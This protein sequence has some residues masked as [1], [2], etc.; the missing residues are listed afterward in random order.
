MLLGRQRELRAIDEGL[1][2]ARL[3]K[4]S[5]LVIRG[6]PGIGK[7]AL[8]EYA[9]QQA[10][11]MRLLAARGVEFEADVP[12]A[13][14][15]ELLQPALGLLD[16]LPSFHAT[17]LRSSL[18]L[19]PRIAA[20]RL[21]V[22]AAVLGLI[23]L[24]AEE[25]PLLITVD[26]AQWLDR[27]SAEAIGFAA[28]RLV[29][30]PVLVL[31]A[32]REG[33][34]SP[35]LAAGLP[36]LMLGGLDQEAA[37]E[38]L[39]NSGGGQ[40]SAEVT[41]RLVAATGGNPL[42][43]LEL[44][45][46]AQRVTSAPH[47]N[48][49]V[50]TSVERAYLRRA[51]G[52]SDSARNVLLLVAASGSSDMGLVRRA[53]A[54]LGVGELAIEEAEAAAS[55]VSQRA[56]RIE[57]VHPLARASIYHSASPAERRAA[58]R[59]L[60]RAMTGADDA[61]RR[62]WH[63]AAAA[64]DHD[65]EAADALEAAARRAHESSGYAAASAAWLESARLTADD[66]TRAARFFQAA[67]NAWLGGRAE[68]A[69]ESLKAARK[70]A[71]EGLQV[72]ID[73]LGGHIAMRRGSVLQ[74]YATLVAAAEAVEPR[75]RLK[76]IRILADAAISTF[77][78]GRPEEMLAA[79]RRAL[80]LLRPDD[81][82][83]AG[84]FAHVS[85]GA[86]AILAGHG[87]D[88]P[89]HL[90]ESVPLFRQLPQD[91]SDPLVLLCA[92]VTGLFLRE[93]E[94]GR[95]LL[96]RALVQAREHAPTGAL[97]SVLFT[98]ARDAFAT[99][100]W[101]LARALYEDAMRVA[102]E[103][104]QLTWLAGDVAGV[105]WLDALEGRADDC[106]TH[107]AEALELAESLGMGLYKAW[108]MI[109]IGM[110]ELGLG[111]PDE[112]LRQLAACDAFLQEISISDPDLSPAPDIVDAL[113]RL[114]R[115]PEAREV[116][117]RYSAAAAAKGQPF[118]LARAARAEALL[119]P[120][121]DFVARFESALRHHES[122]PDTFERART[123][124]YFGERLRRVRKR[125]EA[126]KQLRAALKA[127]DQLGAAP[128]ADRAMS[129]L[130]ASGETA[131]VRDDR[132]RQQLTPQ[133]L[134]VALTLAE[135]TT[136]REAAA[137]L[138]LSPKTVEYHL[139]H[140]YDKL[141]IR[142]R[143][144]LQAALMSHARPG[145]ARKTLMFTDLTSS[146]NL[147]EA[148]G[149]A[150]WHDLSAWLDGELRR[151]FKEHHGHEVDHAGDGFFVIFEAAAE[152]ID[153]AITVQRRLANHRRVHGY[154]PQVRI[155]I[156]SGEVQV[157]DSSVRGAAVHRAARLCA[158]ALGDTIVV[159]REALEASGRPLGGLHDFALKGIKEPVAAAEVS[160]A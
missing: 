120:E 155:G 87:D 55:L 49:P 104:S 6:E 99:D 108:S 89:R 11:S 152:A 137:R 101:A 81:P 31:I 68:D 143:E 35:L 60:G 117:R 10:G 36:D 32:V 116:A 57:F 160:W 109:A 139:R 76:A 98:L 88:G 4:S 148:I 2:A 37:A 5:R 138:Y 64:T 56:G 71:R 142:S 154:A 144:E 134:Q 103:T 111:H 46:E 124:L 17:A 66:A 50:A 150:A 77:G 119:A 27:A 113:A 73:T 29:A 33:E 20:D 19:G 158:A 84:V 47:E 130:Q 42:A 65:S 22:D 94:A 52:L 97:P 43:L 146:T 93:A 140:V 100:R 28:R 21:I 30:D 75:D 131:R 13:G 78:A 92:G 70:L 69:E 110:L 129:E 149:D 132:F 90:H 127:F 121:A 86:L 107:A 3:G 141:E 16:R 15:S 1:A 39:E 128:W 63:L 58:H 79:A 102:R 105:A 156:H 80:E 106:R 157:S 91:S 53:A 126:R 151:C 25:S 123:Q 59:A 9:A 40:V 74:G 118:A 122:T 133:E 18:G 136:T 34:D 26:D 95:E 7:T 23:S 115:V 12:F 145:S 135:G 82:P 159:S 24:Y 62:A 8:L 125:V 45:P 51:A 83:D 14:L 153:C 38:L 44:G 67:D 85:Y 147:V 96:E 54:A 72:E 41:R 114:G 112:A 48:L 61:D